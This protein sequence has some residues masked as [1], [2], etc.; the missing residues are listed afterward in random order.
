MVADTDQALETIASWWRQQL[1]VEVIGVTG[2]VG[3]TTTKELI[4]AVLGQRYNVL[5]SERSLNTTTG[6]EFTLL[7]LDAQHEKAVLEMGMYTTGEIA[8]L[9]RLARPRYGVV[10]NVGPVHLERLGSV[11]A[12]AAAKSELVQALPAD[13]VAI[14]NGDDALVRAMAAKTAAHVFTFGTT[15]G[16][17]LWASD[18]ASRGLDGISFVLHHGDESHEVHAPLPGKH[19]VQT[20]LAAAAVGLVME[21]T[22]AEIIAGMSNVPQRLRLVVVEAANGATLVDDTYNSSPASCLA[23]LDLLGELNG[24]RF[25]ALGDMLE[26]G[27]FEREGHRLVGQ[28]VASVAQGLVV[29]GERARII[30]E[31]AI[32]QGMPGDRVFFAGS[33]AEAVETLRRWTAGRRLRLVEG[34][35]WHEDGRDRTRV[36]MSFAE[37]ER[38]ERSQR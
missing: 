7:R 32:R 33:N 13:G 14:L 31:E 15:P 4:A 20:A 21:L 27:Q 16:L 19:S 29:V 26:L 30:G 36:T 9:C 35:P 22:W 34:I 1:A 17:D 18:I 2:S 25:A 10:T 23:A 8:H 3:K 37:R 11:E 38:C 28:R 24:R 5:K 6:M 12:I